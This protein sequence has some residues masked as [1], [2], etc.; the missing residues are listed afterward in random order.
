MSS[1]VSLRCCGSTGRLSAQEAAYKGI[2]CIIYVACKVRA[3]PLLSG[4]L[5]LRSKLLARVLGSQELYP[6]S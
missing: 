4:R 5:L 3:D 2:F 1:R 6:D